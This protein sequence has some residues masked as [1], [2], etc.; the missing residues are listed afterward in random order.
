MF[1]MEHPCKVIL[2]HGGEQPEDNGWRTT[3]HR[4][5]TERLSV[6]SVC[7]VARRK[8]D[9]AVLAKRRTR[10]R[11]EPMG[12]RSLKGPSFL[13]QSSV[14]PPSTDEEPA[15][16]SRRPP[17]LCE[18]KGPTQWQGA[19]RRV[20][21]WALGGLKARGKVHVTGG[22]LLA[23]NLS[24]MR[25]VVLFNT[26]TMRRTASSASSLCSGIAISDESGL[27]TFR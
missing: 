24:P 7:T 6:I 17:A 15:A 11:C 18:E 3:G 26:V 13:I 22:R 8:C 23:Q 9:I 10:V 16:V 2:C 19:P 4:P 27:N 12:R 5:A 20:A 1:V 21:C 14:N 25:S